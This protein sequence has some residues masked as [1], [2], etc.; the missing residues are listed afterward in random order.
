MRDLQIDDYE[1]I[2]E[3]QSGRKKIG[4]QVPYYLEGMNN[5]GIKADMKSCL[6]R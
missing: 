2:N 1:I 5:E 4:N 3:Q 6:L